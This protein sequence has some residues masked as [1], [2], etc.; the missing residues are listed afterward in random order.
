MSSSPK[1]IKKPIK[2]PQKKS[3]AKISFANAT[4]KSIAIHCC[5]HKTWPALLKKL[6]SAHGAFAKAFGFIAKSGQVCFLPAL[7]EDFATKNNRTKNTANAPAIVAVLFGLGDTSLPNYDAFLPGKLA[8]V[9]PA[10]T[11]HFE[12]L[13]P[14]EDLAALA[15]LLGSYQFSR[16]KKSTKILSKLIAPKTVSANR[17][18][19]L[20][21]AVC[22]GRTLINTPANDL[23]PQELA[24]HAKALGMAFKG[25]VNII[26]GVK[27]AKDFPLL[28]AV[29]RGAVRPPCLVDMRF[30]KPTYPRVTLVGKGVVFDTGG[31]DIKP[32]N[33]MDLMKKDMA[34]AA[35]ALALAQMILAANLPV[36]LRVILPIV[37]NAIGGAAF[38]P[39]DIFMSRKGIS[40]EIG[41]TDAEGRLIL[42]DALALADEE[43]PELL[44]D[45]ATLTGAARVALGPD[46]PPFYTDD[47]A[48]AAA[49]AKHGARVNDPVWR[50]PLWPAYEAMLDSK[51]ADMN[52]APASGMAGSVTAA[53]FLKRFVTQTKSWVHFDIYG[54]VPAAKPG[55]PFGGEIQTARLLFDLLE[56]RMQSK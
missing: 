37:E 6:D 33:G 4:Q 14:R 27:L 7:P 43:K 42:A 3:I 48:L 47:E 18:E 26:A 9:L 22:D 30:G 51:N 40:V 8:E 2:K 56:Q 17:L 49:I 31:L 11:Y 21:N 53:L 39:G 52:N 41:N 50:M 20:A 35:T 28:E 10:G 15:F 13:P 55:R 16:Y 24:A 45:F 19:L 12:T 5:D 23:G 36:R 1:P 25:Q 38:R 29:G 54:W 32:A 46:L 34:G 44:F